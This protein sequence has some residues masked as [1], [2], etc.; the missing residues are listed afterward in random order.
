M[1]ELERR[2]A[3]CQ[4][5]LSHDHYEGS[6]MEKMVKIAVFCVF[7]KNYDDQSKISGVKR[8]YQNVKTIP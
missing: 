3:D 6:Q 5:F 4:D 8:R 7:F 2:I 1:T